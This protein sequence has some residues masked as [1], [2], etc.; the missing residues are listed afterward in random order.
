MEAACQL[1][2]QSETLERELASASTQLYFLPGELIVREMDLS[3]WVY[4][5]HRG[6]IVVARGNE[7][8]TLLTKV[9]LF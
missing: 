6:T 2:N 9:Y 4:I 8:E 1:L 7:K 5:V 3:P